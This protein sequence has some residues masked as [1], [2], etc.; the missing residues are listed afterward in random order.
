MNHLSDRLKEKGAE[1]ARKLFWIFLYLWI[2]LGLFTVHKSLVLSEDN[3][4]Y[5]E[6]F[7][8]INAF[9][10]AKVMLTADM[11]HIADNLKDKPLIFPVFYKSVIF[12]MILI[13]FYFVEETILGKWH[14]KTFAQSIPAI[15]GGSLSGTLTVG[16]IMFVVLMPFFALQEIGRDIGGGDKLYELFFLRRRSL[17]FDASGRH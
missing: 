14:G 16:V 15:G 9:L 4:F 2:L 7:A 6:G 1:E 10:L 13:L 3:F 5:H 17:R 8:V 12:S 11:F